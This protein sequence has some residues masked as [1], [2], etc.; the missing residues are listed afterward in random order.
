[1]RPQRCADEAVAL[2]EGEQLTERVVVRQRLDLEL[3]VDADLDERVALPGSR[4]GDERRRVGR[5]DE[6]DFGARRMKAEALDR[7]AHEPGQHEM[8]RRPGGVELERSLAVGGDAAGSVERDGVAEFFGVHAG[9]TVRSASYPLPMRRLRS[10]SEAE[11]YARCYGGVDAAVHVRRL[12]PRIPR[13]VIAIEGEAVRRR[14]EE[15]LEARDPTELA[16]PEA[17]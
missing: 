17:A 8:F 6:V 3:E 15:Y 14:F 16:E 10:L 9:G 2:G 1:M 11:C 7:A 4:A 13:H 5:R 12:E